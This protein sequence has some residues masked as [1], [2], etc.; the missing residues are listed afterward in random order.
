MKTR[1]LVTLRRL[2]PTMN[3]PGPKKK[4]AAN[5]DYGKE[6]RHREAVAAA[7]KAIDEL[8]AAG[9]TADG[10]T[11]TRVH[12]QMKVDGFPIGDARLI[13]VMD[14]LHSSGYLTLHKLVTGG[15]KSFKRTED[16]NGQP[17]PTD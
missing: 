17:R 6:G 13:K 1:L 12:S 8:A 4:A 14:E 11:R 16:L 15:N 3:R 10:F 9:E 5:G 7:K 2:D